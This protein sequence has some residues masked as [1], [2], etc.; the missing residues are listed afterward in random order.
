MD[1]SKIFKL[2]ELASQ[3]GKVS[4]GTNETTKAIERNVAK[5][6]VFAKD[7]NPPEIVMHLKPLCEEKDIPCFEVQSKK[8]I[9]KAVGISVDCAAAAIID[10]GEGAEIAKEI[11]KEK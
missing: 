5:I 11:E 7:V 6:V 2:L 8:D 3:T 4:K 9:G 1:E 10:F